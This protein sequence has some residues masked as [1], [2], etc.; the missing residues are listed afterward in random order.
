MRSNDLIVIFMHGYSVT[1][2]DTYGEL[3]ARL[4]N[5]ARLRNV[6]LSTHDVFL[7]K[8][9]SFNDEVRLDDLSAALETALKSE[10]YPKYSGQR[11]V[12][13][14][15]SAGGPLVRNWVDMFYKE[16][17]ACPMSHLLMLSPPNHGSAL[18]QLGK[19]RLGKLKSWF[20]GMET[21]Q[22]IL[23]WLELGSR[24]SWSL[25]KN[26]I[27][28]GNKL[29]QNKVFYFV[30]SGQDIDRKLYDHINSYT[31]EPGSD[32]VVRVASANINSAWVRL[33][34]QATLAGEKNSLFKTASFET[35]SPVP[36]RVIRKKSHSNTDMGI[37]RSIKASPDDA[38][39]S[40]TV[41]T[42]FRCMS[43]QDEAQF[44]NLV[45]VFE[46]ETE[47]VQQT[48]RVETEIKN[49]AP[50]Y[51]FHDRHSMVIFRL[52]DSEGHVVADYDLL[53]TAGPGNDPDALP[54]G[55]FRDRQCNCK[56]KSTLTY[57]FN[58]DAMNGAPALTDDE[59]KVIRPSTPGMRSL[60]ITVVARPDK[61]LVHY[62]PAILPAS[63]EN[64]NRM[65]RPNCT[66]LV[67]IILKRIVST[68]VMQLV[69]YDDAQGG[70]NGA[71]DM[72]S[73]I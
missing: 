3:P 20:N 66:T 70:R 5:E 33:E 45:S 48:S 19:S 69:S 51:Y 25:N 36:M 9:I 10:I 67:E 38:Q 15:H 65:I 17:A 50:R 43:V 47:Q 56:D 46:K 30:L 1:S 73:F 13:I 27:L 35:A 28:S 8:Y 64:F 40:E 49:G 42:I 57:F 26:H 53:L 31:G 24:G 23:D 61:G 4:L 12:C 71:E 55:F 58:Y 32:G 63:E 59:G 54:T 68:E 39:N 16:G 6:T 29:P 22:K 11:F 34:Q 37:M 41:D 72:G 18:A 14:T 62:L 7:A 60:G 44:V 2:F 52:R 21:G